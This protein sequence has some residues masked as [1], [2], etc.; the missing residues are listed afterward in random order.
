MRPCRRCA[1]NK[2]F[3]AALDDIF[4]LQDEVASNVAGVIEPKLRQSEIELPSANRPK[5]SMPTI[6]ACGPWPKIHRST[7]EALRATIA[8]VKE[9]SAAHRGAQAPWRTRSP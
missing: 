3:D 1:A 7:D 9:A 8:L 2:H 5:A 4:E 6:C